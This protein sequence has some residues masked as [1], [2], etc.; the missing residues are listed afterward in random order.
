MLIAI[1]PSA[2]IPARP[3][4]AVAK[5]GAAC[6]KGFPPGRRFLVGIGHESLR[7]V[8]RVGSDLRRR[9]RGPPFGTFASR[10]RQLGCSIEPDPVPGG[11][12]P[13]PLDRRAPLGPGSKDL[14]FHNVGRGGSDSARR[15]EGSGL[16]LLVARDSREC[17][18][19]C[20]RHFGVSRCRWRFQ[21]CCVRGQCTGTGL[22]V[23]LPTSTLREDIDGLPEHRSRKRRNARRRRGRFT[24]NPSISWDIIPLRYSRKAAD[25]LNQRLRRGGR[26]G[27]DGCDWH[28]CRPHG[29]RPGARYRRRRRPK[30][31]AI[32]PLLHRVVQQ[33][34]ALSPAGGPRAGGARRDLD[35]T[36]RRR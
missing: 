29:F 13:G 14:R 12:L 9:R 18:K 32:P 21:Q 35:N 1:G 15:A 17:R 10:T 28:Q 7:C 23:G 34:R 5:A 6:R 16:R 11:R 25:R 24:L 3:G 33:A 36:L 27:R 8:V 20:Y 30:W 26:N 31:R 4:S 2:A 22:A 19:R